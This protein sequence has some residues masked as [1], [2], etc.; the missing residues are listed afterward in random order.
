MCR[1]KPRNFGPPSHGCTGVS[2][3][4]STPAIVGCTPD[5][6]VQSQTQTPAMKYMPTERMPRRAIA[7]ITDEP[8]ERRDQPRHADRLGVENRDDEHRHQV[9]DDGQGEHENAEAAWNA[10]A[11]ERHAA[12]DERN[13]GRHRNGPTAFP[14]FA[15]LKRQV[16][17]NRCD[18]TAKR[19]GD[20]QC[21]LLGIA[22][23]SD[24]QLALD[25]EAD[26]EEEDRHQPVVDPM[27][28]RVRELEAAHGDAKLVMPERVVRLGIGRVRRDQRDRRADQENDAA[29]RL[30]V[31]ERRQGPLKALNRAIRQAGDPGVREVVL[32]HRRPAYRGTC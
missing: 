28:E 13:V 4:T 3:P 29:R 27:G 2:K 16:D 18:H 31:H 8:Y 24:D 14:C 6:S 21:D 32:A 19:R 30:D 22:E 5:L 9:V 23:L 26:D 17:R 10:L 7:T 12:D 20:G 15:V 25:F 11:E 1:K